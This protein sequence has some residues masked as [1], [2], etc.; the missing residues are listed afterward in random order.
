MQK[1]QLL[2]VLSFLLNIHHS[3]FAQTIIS[4][5]IIDAITKKNIPYTSIFITNIKIGSYA[6]DKGIIKFNITQDVNQDSAIFS[7]VGY[8]NFK[9]II[10]QLPQIIELEQDVLQIQEVIVLNNYTERFIK[11]DFGNFSGKRFGTHLMPVGSQLVVYVENSE[12]RLGYLEQLHFVFSKHIR[13]GQE[14]HSSKI[15]IR[16]YDIDKYTQKPHQDLLAEP[17]IVEISPRQKQLK[18]DISKYVIPFGK[19]GVFVGIEILGNLDENRNLIP[20]KYQEF[21]QPYPAS[22]K[23]SEINSTAWFSF[24]GNEWYKNK[25]ANS[26]MFGLTARFYEDD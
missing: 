5:K 20:Y 17:V 2:F 1:I 22:I 23:E 26:I 6:N 21:A 24:R 19:E 3:I 7:A 15:R 25:G 10:N 11:Q 18:I 4:T 14:R 13:K 9:V 8:K 16:V 12:K